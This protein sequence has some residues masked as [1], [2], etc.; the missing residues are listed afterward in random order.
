MADDFIDVG[1]T[2]TFHKLNERP[3]FINDIKLAP[4]FC[5]KDKGVYEVITDKNEII[6]SDC[7]LGL[8][9][10]SEGR[11]LYI[12]QK[13]NSYCG[14]FLHLGLVEVGDWCVDELKAQSSGFEYFAHLEYL[15][16]NIKWKNP[17]KKILLTLKN[18]IKESSELVDKM[19]ELEEKYLAY[20]APEALKSDS[21]SPTLEENMAS[22]V[23]IICGDC[24]KTID[25]VVHDRPAGLYI[26]PDSGIGH[27]KS[28]PVCG[29]CYEKYLP[30]TK[31]KEQKLVDALGWDVVYDIKD[32]AR[33]FGGDL[34]AEE[35]LKC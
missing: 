25:G 15:L 23:S 14:R 3:D 9:E 4:V 26:N 32:Y 30:K 28:T 1:D 16:K 11:I 5:T 27:P 13:I 21:S 19:E 18:D 7:I 34:K 33:E 35:N 2:K 12:E 24:K 31:S 8:A 17:P 10:S 20:S 22:G 29:E 6:N